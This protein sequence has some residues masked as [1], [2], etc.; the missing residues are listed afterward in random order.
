M[1]LPQNF[2]YH[3]TPA[4]QKAIERIVPLHQAKIHLAFRAN[5]IYENKEYNNAAIAL[6]EHMI[7]IC[8]PGF[9]IFTLKFFTS[10]HLF[11]ITSISTLD[12]RTAVIEYGNESITICTPVCMR[13]IRSILRNFILSNPSLPANLRFKFTCHNM[14]FFP[15]FHP[16]LSPSQIF[17]FTYNAFCSY[18]DTTYYHE[19]PMFYHSLLTSGNCIFD[20]T[21]L[22]LKILEYGLQDS[23]ELRPITSSLVYTPFTYGF[24][25]NN[26]TRHDIFQSIA[27]II[28]QNESIRIIKITD[29][30]AVDGCVQIAH[31]MENSQNSN[32]VYWDFSKNKLTDTEAFTAALSTYRA[33]VKSI[34]L[35]FCELSDLS[36]SLLFQSITA[37]EYMHDI[38]EISLLGSRINAYNADLIMEF[39]Q[40]IFHNEFIRLKSLHLSYVSNVGQI[41]AFISQSGFQIEKISITNTNLSDSGEVLC[42]FVHN[43][44]KLKYLC[45]DGCKFLKEDMLMLINS[46][47]VNEH[48]EKIDLSLADVNFSS[49]DFEEIFNFFSEKIPLKIRSLVLDGC[50]ISVDNLRSFVQKSS[51]FVRLSKL[52]LSRI[53][54]E[55]TP[56]ISYEL[57]QIANISTLESIIIRGDDSHKLGKDLIQLICALRISPTIKMIDFSN[58]NIGDIG[59]RCLT[60]LVLSCTNIK[61]VVCD[62][63]HP[64]DFSQIASYMDTL[65]TDYS[66]LAAPL[67]VEDIFDLI[68][69]EEENLM[70]RRISEITNLQTRLENNL[71]KN[72]AREGVHSDLTMQDDEI[73]N[74]IIDKATVDLAGLLSNYELKTH[75]A[76]TNVV[77]LPLPFEPEMKQQNSIEN[78]TEDTE[79]NNNYVN[80]E[81]MEVVRE[82]GS[83]IDGLQ[84]LQF[85]SLL[86]RRP[87]A[88]E[89]VG[90]AVHSIYLYELG[91]SDSYDDYDEEEENFEIEDEEEPKPSE[92]NVD[93]VEIEEKDAD[94]E[95]TK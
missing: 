90:K 44:P 56:N 27:P 19:I 38:E 46:I 53:F 52:S 68:V 15:P 61:S 28:E 45:L 78:D 42:D 66:L 95:N 4:E 82:N 9:L 54:K 17:Q 10:F 40:E 35:N 7:T 75:A 58:N 1:Q 57:S 32:I 64:S 83:E 88:A 36:I 72:R 60:N 81:M 13:F 20:L 55:G 89:R 49:D 65:A 23:A 26:F 22:P 6:S 94:E 92:F 12:D 50:N 69:G 70:K 80:S 21:K 31:A 2:D 85:N 84:T 33:P 29:A 62:G 59:L 73:L 93:D 76:I 30:E 51:D 71:S 79:N 25:C 37:N 34:K 39:L 74:E 41:I 87:D 47:G 16:S 11:K 18:Y 63:S 24:V 77:G 67:P 91:E 3:L 43:A 14:D 86:I 48:V 8:T 5:F